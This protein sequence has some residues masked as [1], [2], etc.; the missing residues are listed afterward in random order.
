MIEAILAGLNYG[1]VAL[2]TVVSFVFGVLVVWP[3]I[4]LVAVGVARIISI[5]ARPE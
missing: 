1:L 4:A 5:G 3:L 2:G